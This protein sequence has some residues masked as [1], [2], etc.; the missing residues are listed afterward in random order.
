MV[1]LTANN[2]IP[3]H[4]ATDVREI[5]KL[6]W[7]AGEK[8]SQHDVYFSTDQTAVADATAVTPDIYRGRQD[9]DATSYI[10]AESPLQW[11]QSYYWR[12]DE[13]EADGTIH[14]GD[15]WN[16]TVANFK[17]VDDFE[18]YTDF[19][20]DR[21]FDSWIDGWGNP[22]NGSTVGYAEPDFVAGEHF[23]ETQ[24]VHSH[25][26]SMPLFYD[27][28]FMYSEATMTLTY[29]RDWT[30]N[31]VS[32]L[33]LW[34]RGDPANAAERMYVALNDSA[35][36]YHNDPGVAQLAEWTQWN[37]DLQEFAAQG[38]NLTNVNTISIGFGDKNNIKAGGSGLVFFDD[39]RL[40]PPAP[41]PAP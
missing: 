21:I 12:I 22:I 34:F 17:V 8:A 2:P 32:T 16:F 5:P 28:N 31:G 14:K 7:L 18:Y 6:R 1:R 36:V 24:I 20:P 3:P 25:Q 35:V 30:E 13:I 29:P 33:T 38:V 37:I 19:E 4:R 40:Y 27:N 11:G 39:I 26:Q 15:V 9:L 10:P 23:V 41:E